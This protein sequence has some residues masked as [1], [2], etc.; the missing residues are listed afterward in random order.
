MPGTS[1][2]ISGGTGASG[3]QLVNTVLAQFPDFNVQVLTKAMF[4]MSKSCKKP[5]I[6]LNSADEIVKII[7]RRFGNKNDEPDVSPNEADLE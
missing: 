3:L 1:Y 2:I 7:T 4:I 6:R 5:L